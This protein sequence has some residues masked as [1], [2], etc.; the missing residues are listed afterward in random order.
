LKK[1][2]KGFLIAIGSLL[3]LLGLGVVAIIG[4]FATDQWSVQ[5]K[6]KEYKKAL[7]I[8]SSFTDFLQAH[9][10]FTSLGVTSDAGPCLQ[11][12]RWKAAEYRLN[13]ERQ[14]QTWA[15][16][17]PK[18]QEALR[19]PEC[20]NVRLLFFRGDAGSGFWR[21]SMSLSVDSEGRVTSEP[22]FNIYS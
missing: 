10:N 21:G 17:F 9:P 2:I 5:S 12:S 7:P 20:R 13:N 18:I 4:Y 1:L 11:V 8:S 14:T 22:A 3:G 16:V 6:A 15:T 19:K